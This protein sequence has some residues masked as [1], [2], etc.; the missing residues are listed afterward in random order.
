M[1]GEIELRQSGPASV[2]HVRNA[3]V[4]HKPDDLRLAPG[5]ITQGVNE[6][7]NFQ[8]STASQSRIG[9]GSSPPRGSVP[10]LASGGNSKGFASGLRRYRANIFMYSGHRTKAP[11]T[12]NQATFNI[13]SWT[14]PQKVARPSTG[15]EP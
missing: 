14:C 1:I 7:L 10:E 6:L 9:L 3:V 12:Q 8:V 2:R 13:L 4:G 5:H 15:G 11:G